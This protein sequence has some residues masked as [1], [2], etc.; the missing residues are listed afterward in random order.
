MHPYFAQELARERRRE[1]LGTAAVPTKAT[2]DNERD[3][4]TA[5]QAP[6]ASLDRTRPSFVGPGARRTGYPTSRRWP[7]RPRAL[8]HPAMTG[9]TTRGRRGSGSVPQR[10]LEVA[11]VLLGLLEQGA[12][13]LGHVGQFELVGLGEAL[14]VA[15]ELVALETQVGLEGQ[16]GCRRPLHRG[17]ADD[18]LAA[19]ERD[20]FGQYLGVG[21]SW[22]TWTLSSSRML[23][24]S[25]PVMVAM[26]LV[27]CTIDWYSVPRSSLRS[28]TNF[29]DA[30]VRCVCHAL[31]VPRAGAL[32]T[33]AVESKKSK[34]DQASFRTPAP[35]SDEASSPTS[36]RP[37]LASSCSSST[38]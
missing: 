16:R 33:R 12:Q 36:S 6:K 35:I 27:Y 7:G 20:L 28:S 32:Y 31:S 29:S 30:D 23:R 3:Q 21:S 2:S 18:G 34:P 22:P 14:A 13:G 38:G 25:A 4:S 1:L 9:R 24:Y 15:L 10:R 5:A 37:R 19:Q 17:D 8:H 26:W 11:H